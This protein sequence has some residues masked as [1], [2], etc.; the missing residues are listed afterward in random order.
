[1][2]SNQWRLKKTKNEKYDGCAK[3]NKITN[4]TKPCE[5]QI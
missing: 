1:M 2:A 4:I 3:N 5:N